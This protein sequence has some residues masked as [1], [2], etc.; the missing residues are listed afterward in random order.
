M[1]GI[2]VVKSFSKHMHIY[3]EIRT[4]KKLFGVVKQTLAVTGL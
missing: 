4:W 3:T 1:K 2:R